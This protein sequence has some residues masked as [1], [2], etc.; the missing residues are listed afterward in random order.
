M[1]DK[2][3]ILQAYGVALQLLFKFF[4]ESFTAAQGDADA[5]AGAEQRFKKGVAHLRHVRDRALQ[6]L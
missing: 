4:S 1:G 2:E 3:Y 5:E 6:L